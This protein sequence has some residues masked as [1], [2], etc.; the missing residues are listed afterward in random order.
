MKNVSFDNPYLLLIF[1]PLAIALTIPSIIAM[2]KGIRSKSV[3]VS[4]AIHIVIAIVATLA[5][6][7][8]KTET[9]ITKTEVFVVADVSY[10]S[11]RTLDEVDKIVSDVTNKAPK[12]SEIGLICFAK[13]PQ[14]LVNIG[15]ELVSVKE[16]TVDKD[17]T[18]IS[19][20]LN[21]ASDRFSND[22]IKRIVLIT[23]GKQTTGN[24]EGKLIS[25][26]ENLYAR[27]IFIDVVYVD[28]NLG[29][30]DKELQISDIDYTPSTYI[31][32]ETTLDLVIQSTYEAL[33]IIKLYKDGELINETVPKAPLV[34]GFNIVNIPLVTDT[35]GSFDYKIELDTHEIEDISSQNNTYSFTQR[36]SGEL[37]VLL[38]T[39]S[40]DDISKAEQLYGEDATIVACGSA[41]NMP[42][43][44]DIE[45]ICQ[46]DEIIVSNIDL[47][48]LENY[49]AFI[50]CV[51]VAVSSFGKTLITMGDLK[52]QNTTD[53][54]LKQLENFLP[55]NFGNDNEESKLFTI[56]IDIS[57]SMQ[58][59]SQLII[60]KRAAVQLMSLLNDNDYVC[61]VAFSGDVTV[62]QAPVKAV[63]RDI[64]EAEVI[65]KIRPSQGTV[66]GAALDETFKTIVNLPYKDKQVMLIT[67][68]DSYSMEVDNPTNVAKNM[69]QQGI[70]TSTIGVLPPT[71]DDVNLLKNIASYGGGDYYSVE[72][73]K[74]LEALMFG[75]IAD[76]IT[77]SVVEESSPVNIEIPNDKNVDGIYSLPNVDGFVFSSKKPSAT[78]VLTT[79]YESKSEEVSNPPI[80]A[81]WKY[82]NGTVCTFTST[83]S[84]EWSAPW[85]DT[86]GESFLSNLVS[87]NTPS[88]KVDFPYNLN[89]EFDGVNSTVELIPA[90]INP[91]ANV[92]L[93][94]IMPSE[95]IVIADTQSG[96]S[97][98]S[99]SYGY[100]FATPYI[101]KYDIKV[102]YSYGEK[103][104]ESYSSFNISYSPEYDSFAI[105]NPAVLH[106]AVRNRGTVN[107]GIVPE[108]TNEGK[109]VRMYV[110]SFIIPLL[111]S[112]VALFVIDIMV[113]K[114]K[115]N[116]IKGLFKWTKKLG[117]KA[118]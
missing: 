74:D 26:I 53:A 98:N 82:G 102:T 93:E 67:D 111:I 65:D 39:A 91:Y 3:V 87:V 80:Y 110:V 45:E 76:K 79:K 24:A 28:N 43:P 69:K 101:G 18:D 113:R 115:W 52:L 44:C 41:N 48:Q 40:Q 37:K 70:I 58:D 61:I 5:L 38:V 85:N 60:A 14:V 49:S 107:E 105:F 10:S 62:I 66:I 118:K 109:E 77:V 100:S 90:I 51:D 55:V 21:Y 78:T 75:K 88:E 12:G 11:N 50:N 35:A 7:G 36:V 86:E 112:A 16:S 20:A 103:S 19:E 97:F 73:E 33:P 15:E 9:V 46:Y 84:G 56:V 4:F 117:G 94:I 34:K 81:Y 27:D 8:M 22:T 95:E 71:G 29:E 59:S 68:G 104:Y 92:K 2:V 23:D 47:S 106:A 6:A 116:D 108:M 25:A 57:R 64:I 17:A 42:L 13:T 89:V 96:V 1:I 32:H 31:N 63:K 30:N 83:M 54:T 99:T 114:L 72:R